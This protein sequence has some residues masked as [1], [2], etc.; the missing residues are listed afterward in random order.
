MTTTTAFSAIL[1]WF[2]GRRLS[3]PGWSGIVLVVNNSL[4]TF[5]L[6]FGSL[7]GTLLWMLSAFA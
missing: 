7:D 1:A 2:G 3:V 4:S 5:T 6:S